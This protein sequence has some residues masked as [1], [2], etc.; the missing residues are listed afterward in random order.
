MDKTQ[1]KEKLSALYDGESTIQEFQDGL[2]VLSTNPGLKKTLH[3]YAMISEVMQRKANKKSSKVTQLLNYLPTL[4]PIL[5]NALTAAA[6]VLITLLAIYQ[7]DDHRFRADRGSAL[8][9]SS[10]LSS[11][12]AKNQLLNA[13]QNIM[14]H[15]INIMQSNQ[16]HDLQAISNDWIPVGFTRTQRNSNQYTNGKDN[17][18]FHIANKQ[19]GIKKVKYYKANQNWIYLIPLK[20]GR[21]LTAYGNMPPEIAKKMIQDINNRK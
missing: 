21:L 17:L 9:L 15:L 8:Q 14:E 4:N 18:Y 2:E 7:F 20:D 13:D 12:E 3:Q 10:A 19:L 1:E 16:P 5:G 11:D 6:T